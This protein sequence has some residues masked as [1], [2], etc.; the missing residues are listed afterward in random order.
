M[1]G[2]VLHRRGGDLTRRPPQRGWAALTGT[3]RR[4]V[5]LAAQ[6]L[7][8]AAIGEHLFISRRTV[9]T[10]LTHVFAKLGVASRVELAAAYARRE[11]APPLRLAH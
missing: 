3:E 6:G 1:R 10:H 11:D 7:T 2:V 9:E 8:N 4:V 5:Q